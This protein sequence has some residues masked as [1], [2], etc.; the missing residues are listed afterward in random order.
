MCEHG[1]K[2]II[3][4]ARLSIANFEGAMIIADLLKLYSFLNTIPTKYQN[5]MPEQFQRTPHILDNERKNQNRP[6]IQRKLYL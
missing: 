6:D 4:A 2:E 3:K 5:S 1:L